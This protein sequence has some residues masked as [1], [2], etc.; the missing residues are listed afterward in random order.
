MSLLCVP[1]KI[2]LQ[3]LRWRCIECAINHYR[4]VHVEWQPYIPVARTS[5]NTVISSGNL[6][7]C[8]LPQCEA[9]RTCHLGFLIITKWCCAQNVKVVP[10]AAFTK[11]TCNR[12]GSLQKGEDVVATYWLALHWMSNSP[13]TGSARRITPIHMWCEQAIKE[14]SWWVTS[15]NA[16]EASEQLIVLANG[17]NESYLVR[18]SLLLL[19]AT[20]WSFAYLPL[21]LSYPTNPH[22]YSSWTNHRSITP[23]GT[24]STTDL[25][26]LLMQDIK[27]S[28]FAK[29]SSQL[30]IN[31]VW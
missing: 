16:C 21:G 10:G 20:V 17:N 9:L 7:C 19:A 1:F 27:D 5:N 2:L 28:F 22:L 24:R 23:A 8:L 3:P 29:K 31:T 6:Y 14:W 13:Q 12:C 25:D 26:I 30:L 11:R 4:D 18:W 15:N